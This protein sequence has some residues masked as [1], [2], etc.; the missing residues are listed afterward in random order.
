MP[1]ALY[2]KQDTVPLN[3]MQSA[4]LKVSLNELQPNE[5]HNKEIHFV[6]TM[7]SEAL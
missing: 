1:P 2:L 7:K 6:T 4:I 3:S 5:L